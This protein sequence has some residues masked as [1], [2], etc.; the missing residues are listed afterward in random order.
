MAPGL[1]GNAAGNSASKDAGPSY[2]L[3]ATHRDRT[4]I[5]IDWDDTL[6]PTSFLANHGLS[7]EEFHALELEPEAKLVLDELDKSASALLR[8]A[9][10]LARNVTVVTNAEESWVEMSS[11]KFLPGV[12]AMLGNLE[13]VSA[14]S[15][16]ESTHPD[17]TQI[18]K[19]VEFAQ[20]VEAR[21]CFS[22]LG[23]LAY[24]ANPSLSAGH[25]PIHPCP[26]ASA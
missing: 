8:K 2:R 1:V 22:L 12:F 17:E 3:P 9:R 15:K 6:L 7:V 13:V 25:D 24:D 16:H 10:A 20:R 14:R 26:R 11:Q 23:P 18:W 19:R 4:Q 21:R 5:L